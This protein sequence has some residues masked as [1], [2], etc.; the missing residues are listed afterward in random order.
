MTKEQAREHLQKVQ[1]GRVRKNIDINTTRGLIS[2]INGR[3]R[4][5]RDYEY[6][7]SRSTAQLLEEVTE[8]TK[9]YDELIAELDELTEEVSP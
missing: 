3:L 4:I 5:I 7:T 8:L 2:A 1:I 9:L 6:N